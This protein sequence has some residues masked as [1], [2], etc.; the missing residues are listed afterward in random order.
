MAMELLESI[1]TIEALESIIDH[2]GVGIHYPWG[3]KNHNDWKPI[4]SK[5]ERKSKRA[6]RWALRCLRLE[7][8]EYAKDIFYLSACT[9]FL[10]IFFSFLCVIIIVNNG[11]SLQKIVKYPSKET[12]I[13]VLNE[14]WVLVIFY[15]V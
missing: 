8:W 1:S 14:V 10:L 3:I 13:V 2:E 11:A 4:D 6:A 7:N 15:K 9:I 5:R 12:T